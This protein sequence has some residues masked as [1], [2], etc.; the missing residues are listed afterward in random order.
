MLAFTS[1]KTIDCV[2]HLSQPPQT[3]SVELHTEPEEFR[4]IARCDLCIARSGGL[5]APCRQDGG[6]LVVQLLDLIGGRLLLQPEH[7]AI[8]DE[9]LRVIVLIESADFFRCAFTAQP[10]DC[11]VG[12]CTC[13]ARFVI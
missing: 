11:T 13:I 12:G 7:E 5:D 1:D 4:M 3:P 6:V 10:I 8:T 2:D 9:P